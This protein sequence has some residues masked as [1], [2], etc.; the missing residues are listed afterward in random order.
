MVFYDALFCKWT[1]DLRLI[2]FC[3]YALHL[4]DVRFS[5]IKLPFVLEIPIY[6]FRFFLYLGHLY[7]FL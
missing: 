1:G 3:K 2:L 7:V 6:G 5:N 4:L